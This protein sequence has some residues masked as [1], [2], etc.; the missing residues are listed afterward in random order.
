MLDIPFLSGSPSGQ[1]LALCPTSASL[2]DM[3]YLAG[4]RPN[5]HILDSPVPSFTVVIAD[6]TQKQ[7]YRS[8]RQEVFVGEQAIFAESDRDELDDD[9][10][11]VVLVAVTTGDS[12]EVGDARASSNQILGGVRIHPTKEALD[13]TRDEQH[14]EGRD[15]GWWAGSRLVV[16]SNARTDGPSSAHVGSALVMRACQEAEAR[17]VLRFEATVQ[18]NNERL[19]TRLGWVI[20]SRGT[21]YGVPHVTMRWPIDRIQ[22]LAA[23][24]KNPL[25]ELVGGFAEGPKGSASREHG[26]GGHGFIGDD[27][28]PV[29]GTH[30]IAACDAILP[31]LVNED[32]RWAGWCSVLVNINDIAAMGAM[33]AGLVDAVAARDQCTVAQVLEGIRAAAEAWDVPVVGGHTQFGIEPSLCVTALGV[34]QKPVP[35]GGGQAGDALNLTV[36]L[37]GRWRPGFEGQQWDSTSFRTSKQ[38]QFMNGL[39]R[40][41][42]P[43]AAKDVSM[44]GMIGTAGMLAEASGTGVEIDVMSI[45]VPSKSA[46]R[47]SFGDWVTC[48][49]GFAM[50]TADQTAGRYSRS[51]MVR[52]N[53]MAQVLAGARSAG[54]TRQE[55]P[56]ELVSTT[57]GQLTEREGVRLR[58]PDGLVDE[59]TLPSVTGLGRA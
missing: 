5:A 46:T 17:G 10:R 39:V 52:F 13:Y 38:L 3:P 34:A 2:P 21:Y 50:L 49:P 42:Q 15:I 26:L 23:R 56:D 7:Q 18:S 41:A 19:F 25:G 53:S 27:G 12:T 36:D 59:I 14:T 45:P 37:G 43:S 55:I 20:T 4:S 57:I 33:P 51:E 54:G 1:S 35:G 6:E 8:L 48:F 58:W 44:A 30:T 11:T 29:P 40:E 28:A 31:A 22:K 47:P 9:T 16:R 32:P 24:T